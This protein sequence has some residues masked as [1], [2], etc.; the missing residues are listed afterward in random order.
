M[1]G[2]F[3]GD[4]GEDEDLDWCFL[5]EG[6]DEDLLFSLVSGSDF[7]CLENICGR[8]MD[9]DVAGLGVSFS[10][11]GNFRGAG[12]LRHSTIEIIATF[13]DTLRCWPDVLCTGENRK[14]GQTSETIYLKW[15]GVLKKFSR[16]THGVSG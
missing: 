1:F 5:G 10:S 2:D 3:E 11:N 6:R 14:L 4:W 15:Y 12:S 13:L 8:T 7:F 9:D 16:F